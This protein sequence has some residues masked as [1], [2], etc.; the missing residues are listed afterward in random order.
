MVLPDLRSPPQSGP[1]ASGSHLASPPVRRGERPTAMGLGQL[2]QG[3]TPPG[4][5][6]SLDS[7]GLVRRRCCN[8]ARSWGRDRKTFPEACRSGALRGLPPAGARALLPGLLWTSAPPAAPVP[9]GISTTSQFE[10][11]D[12][13]DPP[14]MQLQLKPFSSPPPS[15]LTNTL[16]PTRTPHRV[17]FLFC[18]SSPLTPPYPPS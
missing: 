2:D 8:P 16:S 14:E 17:S 1:P 10:A 7:S 13:L 3:T 11:M 6:A 12:S 18:S 5:T 9:A 4:S 15:P